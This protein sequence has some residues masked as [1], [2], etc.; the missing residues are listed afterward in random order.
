MLRFILCMLLVA[1]LLKITQTD[2][3][4]GFGLYLTLGVS[5]MVYS[6]NRVDCEDLEERNR[7]LK[8]PDTARYYYQVINSK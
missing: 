4:V 6:L 1:V 7:L 2:P 3:Y 5:F 8:N